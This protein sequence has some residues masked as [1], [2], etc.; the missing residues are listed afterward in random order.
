VAAP[1]SKRY[2]GSLARCRAVLRA[3]LTDALG[4]DPAA[5]YS[6]TACAAAGR[7]RNQ[8]CFDS[9]AF[10]ATG[11]ATQPMIGWQNRPTYQQAVEVQ[12]HRPRP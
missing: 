8:V 5:L 12:G 11:G 1:Y 10:R 7:P 2:C 9:I 3:A 6:D 4:D